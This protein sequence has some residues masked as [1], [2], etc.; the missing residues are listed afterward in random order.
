[1]GVLLKSAKNNSRWR[2]GFG[3]EV[4]RDLFRLLWI[5][6]LLKKAAMKLLKKFSIMGKAAWQMGRQTYNAQRFV[7]T[8]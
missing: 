5:P 2:L 6:K 7:V 8:I 4:M 3:E 1:M